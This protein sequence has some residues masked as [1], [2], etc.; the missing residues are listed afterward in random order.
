[1]HAVWALCRRASAH[2]AAVSS[3]AVTRKTCTAS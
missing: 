1:M 2:E 3:G